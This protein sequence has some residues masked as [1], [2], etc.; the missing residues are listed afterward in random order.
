MKIL[1]KIKIVNMYILIFSL[2][3]VLQKYTLGLI[4]QIKDLVVFERFYFHELFFT[5]N[6]VLFIILFVRAG[7]PKKG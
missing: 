7:I 1:D 6:A 3:F 5:F 4:P 2:L